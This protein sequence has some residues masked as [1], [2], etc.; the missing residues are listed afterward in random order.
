M[1]IAIDITYSPSG[2]SLTQIV[3][4][5]EI[6]NQTDGLDIVIYS[7]KSNNNLLAD[8]TKDN[9]VIISKLA[10]LSNIG[11]M[12]WGQFFLP[13]Y[14]IKEKVDVLFCPGN[15]GPIFC[16]VKTVIWIHT[17]GPFFKEFIRH[18]LW[19]SK[20]Q[21]KVKLYINKF[22]MVLSALKADAVIFESQF[23]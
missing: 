7:K 16:P 22:F 23:T 2:G 15:F 1:K 3:K 19:I 4:M 10:N 6:F 14:L 18:F 20:G 9:K 21:N 8:L 17:I 11:R 12:I 13:F 5:I